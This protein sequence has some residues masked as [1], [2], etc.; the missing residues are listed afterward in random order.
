[1]KT[2][3]KGF[4]LIELATVMGIVALVLGGVWLGVAAVKRNLALN[5]EV[6]SIQ[7][8]VENIRYF[9]KNISVPSNASFNGSVGWN[10]G[11]YKGAEAFSLSG[12]ATLDAFGKNT[13]IS[14]LVPAACRSGEQCIR[15]DIYNLTT[16]VCI[17]LVSKLSSAF[18]DTT[19]LQAVY[20]ENTGTWITT[21]PY[22]PTAA[23]CGASTRVLFEFKG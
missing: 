17:S 4:N 7:I 5:Q 16:D 1:M 22:I 18:N 15:V 9:Y 12:N 14:L 11:L 8:I 3:P 10:M 23:V 13:I 2:A 20:I 6:K 19:N 21:F